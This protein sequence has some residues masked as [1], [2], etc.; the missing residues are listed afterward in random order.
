MEHPIVSCFPHYPAV[1]RALPFIF[2]I[3]GVWV[4]WRLGKRV[5]GDA[6]GIVAAFLAAISPWHVAASGFG[7]YYSFLYLLA[8]LAYLTVPDAIDRDDRGA[9]L[10]ALIVLLLGAWTHPSFVFPVGAAI[11]GVMLMDFNGR[12]RWRWPTPTAWTYLWG[13]FLVISALGIVAIRM[14]RPTTG[15]A[16]GG[17]RGLAAT[18]RLVPAIVDLMTPIVFVAAVI[19]G[20]LLIRSRTP[21][22]RQLGVMS[23]FGVGGMLLAL[24]ILSFKTA[25]YADYGVSALPLIFVAA[26]GLVTWISQAATTQQRTAV[27]VTVM[28]LITVAVLPALVSHLSDGTRFDYRPAYAR[29]SRDAPGATVLTSPIVLQRWYAPTLHGIELP[30]RRSRL[31]SLLTRTGGLWAVTS[32]KRY[33]VVGDADGE[34]TAWL[35]E[36]CRPIDQYQRPRVDYRMYRVDVWHCTIGS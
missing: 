36:R 14:A 21:G 4:T 22:W 20:V 25:I 5:F 19:G 13:P 29:I 31:D 24:F 35:N 8:G 10:R 28:T 16:N 27:T 26:A 18:L 15:V 12:T 1:L 17:D 23:V 30:F 11:L 7:R 34:L 9:Y 32:V 6:G 33:G 2:G 3:L